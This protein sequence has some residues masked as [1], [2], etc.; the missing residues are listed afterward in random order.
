[1]SKIRYLARVGDGGLVDYVLEQEIS[2][3]DFSRIPIPE[4]MFDVTD[5]HQRGSGTVET[6]LL[7]PYDVNTKTFGEKLTLDEARAV[8]LAAQEAPAEEL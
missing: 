8:V 2:H 1:M 4:G 3:G 7:R 5:H 6:L